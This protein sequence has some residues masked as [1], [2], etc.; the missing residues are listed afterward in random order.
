M[1]TLFGI[2]FQGLGSFCCPHCFAKQMALVVLLLLKMQLL[3]HC[4]LYA[5]QCLSLLLVPP[6]GE[7]PLH[8]LLLYGVLWPHILLWCKL[9]Q[10]F[11]T[12]HVPQVFVPLSHCHPC[13]VVGLLWT[14][15]LITL[16]Y[17]GFQIIAIVHQHSG[18]VIPEC[19]WISIGIVKTIVTSI[20]GAVRCGLSTW[21]FWGLRDQ[22][23][24]KSQSDLG[25]RHPTFWVLQLLLRSHAH[26]WSTS[27]ARQWISWT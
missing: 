26:M 25:V 2:A 8:W 1:G 6:V 5:F 19:E 15:L 21:M 11:G 24:S 20:F 27:I 3:S 23:Q 13:Q 14:S 9:P 16:Y 22:L 18:F 4:H 7:A 10:P 12:F 17:L